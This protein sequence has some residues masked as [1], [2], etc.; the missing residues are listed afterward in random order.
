MS[1]IPVLLATLKAILIAAAL[2]SSTAD[3]LPVIVISLLFKLA[4]FRKQP[5]DQTGPP[6]DGG[7]FTEA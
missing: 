2:S 7:G 1:K 6:Q 3:G 4:H 5:A